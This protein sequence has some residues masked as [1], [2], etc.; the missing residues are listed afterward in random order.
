MNT[1]EKIDTEERKENNQRVNTENGST[2]IPVVG[3]LSGTGVT[4]YSRSSTWRN[5]GSE[6]PQIYEIH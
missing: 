5:I 6:S 4:E 1:G 3:G 2:N